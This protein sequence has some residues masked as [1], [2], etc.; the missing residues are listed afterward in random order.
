MSVVLAA[1]TNHAPGITGRRAGAPKEEVD[2]YFEKLDALRESIESADL[3]ALLFVTAEHFTN[4][5]MD[6]MPA[7]CI[8]LNDAFEGPVEPEKYLKLNKTTV[9]ANPDLAK[10]FA[11]EIMADIDLSYSYEMQFDHGV[12][13]PLNFLT[14]DYDI[15]IIPIIINCLFRPYPAL[16]RCY[17]LGRCMRR[18]GDKTDQRIGIIG[19]GGLSHWPAMSRSGDINVEWDKKFIDD[20]IRNDYAALTAYNDDEMDRIAGAGAQEVRAWLTVAGATAGST[21]DLLFYKPLP[22]F[23]IGGTV[24]TMTIEDHE[25]TKG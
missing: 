24:A 1:V 14:P 7:F 22:S 23:A 5:F 17:E 20:F 21:G 15:P 8:G 25:T 11:A 9:P 16:R 4:F 19:T 3:D 12:M 2:P 18:A 6:N 10:W 13:V